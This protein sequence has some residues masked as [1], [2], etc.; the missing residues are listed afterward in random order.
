MI[1][2]RF[3]CTVWFVCTVY[4]A[5]ALAGR[6]L[7]VA[8][9]G[10]DSNPGTD[11]QPLKTLKSAY[12]QLRHNGGGG[13]V[14][15]RG[16]RYRLTDTWKLRQ[17]VSGSPGRPVVFRAYSN[18]TAVICGGEVLKVGTL[19]TVRD[20]G[21]L[22][23][24]K[25][26]VRGKVL[27]MDLGSCGADAPVWPD[28]FKG[29]AGWPEIFAD[30]KPFRLAR[31]PDSGYAKAVEIIDRGSKPRQGES[32]NRGGAFRYSG[33][34]PERWDIADQDVYLNGYWCY[35]WA[36]EIIKVAA[37]NPSNQT[38]RL[39]AAHTYGLGGPSGCQYYAFNLL[40]E[41]DRPGEYVVDCRRGRIYL[42]LPENTPPDTELHI[43]LL[44][45]NLLEISK[46]VNIRFENITFGECAG[47]AVELKNCRQV[48]FRNCT[49][50]NIGGNGVAINGGECC[51][52]QN[53][54]VFNIGKTAVALKGGKRSTLEASGHF[55]SD[56]HI[57]HYARLAKT[58]CAAV[59]LKGVGQ[60]VTFNYIHDAPHNAV[61]FGGNDH[62]IANNRIERVCLDTSDAGAIYCGRNWTL[63]GNIIRNNLIADLGAAD[64]L[65][66]WGVYLDDVASGV[67]VTGNVVLNGPSGMLIGGGRN[68]SITDNIFINCKVRAAIYYDERGLHGRWTTPVRGDPASAGNVL[69]KRLDEVPYKQEPWL[70]RFPYLAE[71]DADPA[72][73]APKNAMVAG[74]L[75]W[76]CA[77]NRFA[78]A[79]LK[80]GTVTNNFS[81]ADEI[82]VS[83]ENGY[84]LLVSGDH[85]CKSL[86][87]F[88]V[89]P[90]TSLF[91]TQD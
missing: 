81:V 69:W 77:S 5:V 57:H 64:Q 87:S 50:K 16:G 49:F 18:E 26:E 82:S 23:R 37:I 71:L 68:N 61:L 10:N 89:G 8:P 54:Q 86:A 91:Q 2:L 43:S 28:N 4:A 39:A 42:L 67:T 60:R 27:E 75:C 56:C 19:R 1:K 17:D 70:S 62:L 85:N 58:Y 78:P 47:N 34:E 29:Y 15:L 66:N 30:D 53:C 51:G 41:L 73:G 40:E 14:L 90:H 38:I 55:V 74:N 72:P 32:D 36:D 83:M 20:A 12:E 6:T 21:V 9:G 79:V 52:L 44:R 46:V 65:N 7:F 63:G 13:V 31:W 33:N 80:F 11:V 76:N 35:E 3:I 24:L 45:R 25:P 88:E 59:A 48:V 22:R 84:I